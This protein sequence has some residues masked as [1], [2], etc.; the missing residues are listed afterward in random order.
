M[1]RSHETPFSGK[2]SGFTLLFEA[3]V[4]M[5]ARRMPFAAV[6]RIAGISSYQALTICQRYVELALERA[7]FSQV[8]ALAVDEISTLMRGNPLDF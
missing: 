2:L 1:G 8:T 5:L 3:L 4:L 7:D 6:S